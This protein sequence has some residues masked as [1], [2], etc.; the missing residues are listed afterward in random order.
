MGGGH[1]QIRLPPR[2]LYG[3]LPGGGSPCQGYY[4]LLDPL[5]LCFWGELRTQQPYLMS[6][7]Q[8]GPKQVGGREELYEVTAI[9]THPWSSFS[10]SN[11]GPILVTVTPCSNPSETLKT[12]K[13][14]V[15]PLSKAPMAPA[16]LGII[17][18]PYSW[19]MP[20]TNA[21]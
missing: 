13:V 5:P 15:Q 3:L 1:F 8:D 20:S 21:S 11:Q 18:H 12:Y 4:Q 10:F 9:H 17:A 19:L 2:A 16:C 7:H 6:P 14:K